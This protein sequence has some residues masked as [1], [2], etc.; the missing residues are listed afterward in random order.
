MCN[1]RTEQ[2]DRL[3]D[4]GDVISASR[5]LD[6]RAAAD[7]SDPRLLVA[8][9]RF[10]SLLGRYVDARVLLDRALEVDPSYVDG[11]IERARLAVRMA[12][13]TRAEGW[14][15]QAR[16]AGATPGDWIVDWI[17]VLLRERRFDEARNIA[18]AHCERSPKHA[19]VWF[20][21]G[22]A[23]QQARHLLQALDAYRHAERLESTLPMLANNIAAA[24]IEL[25]EFEVA[26]RVLERIVQENPDNALAWTNL[27]T[28]YLK[29]GNIQDSLVAAERACALAPR[30][31]VALQTYSYV[32]KEMQQWD[33]ALAVAL[34]AAQL[35]SGNPSLIWTV[36]MLQLLLGDY[37]TGWISHEARWSGSPE[38]R[39]VDPHLPSPLWNGEP[40]EGKTLLLWC[41]QGYGDVMQFVRFVPLIASRVRQAGGTLIYCCFDKLLSLVERGLSDTVDCII[42]HEHR[43]LPHSDYH[44]P[45]CSLPRVLQIS[46]DD[47]PVATGYLKPDPLKVEAWR[48]R[49][50]AHTRI[51]VGL[52]W[53]GSRSHQ[54]N[55]LRSVPITDL[56]HALRG[57]DG[58]EFFNLQVDAGDERKKAREIGLTLSDYTAEFE[59]FDDT[60]AFVANLDLVITVCTS[61]AH[62]AGAMNVPT[63]VL[64]DV[65][66]HWV[67]MSSRS[68]SPWYPSVTLYR[69][70]G[71]R[72]WQPVLD[73]I[74]RDLENFIRQ[75]AGKQMDTQ[76][77]VS[78]LRLGIAQG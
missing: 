65:N 5:L 36:A 26:A 13:D 75:H 53:S 64:L 4:R 19:G 58:V 8:A 51:K 25:G 29:L 61:V 22:L 15:R 59:S 74:A 18:A 78:A 47:L 40:L 6:I 31:P 56:A 38:L 69:Q 50:P 30:L 34:A 41:E 46:L 76:M 33:A 63:W 45:L 73:R 67:W 12:D 16:A 20:R 14:F 2:L 1:V 62:M 27:S 3:I 35:D 7:S 55:P 54:R 37:Q 49:F 28:A 48:T 23:H 70:Q 24:H 39:D 60:A 21:L 11:L 77:A 72:Q 9:S 32:L 71:Y 66:P 52:A 44:L 57:F 43:P 10:L 17:D 42:S 68:D